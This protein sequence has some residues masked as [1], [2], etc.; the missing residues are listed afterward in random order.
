M[1]QT[2]SLSVNEKTLH[3]FPVSETFSL[4]HVWHWVE[5]FSSKAEA[6]R[7]IGID[8]SYLSKILSGERDLT[9][10]IQ[11]RIIKSITRNTR[12]TTRKTA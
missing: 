3:I 6:A 5:S 8:R 2:A 4:P 7:Q 10:D 9:E 1:L 12:D 11:Q